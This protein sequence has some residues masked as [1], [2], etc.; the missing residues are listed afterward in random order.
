MKPNFENE[1]PE[2]SKPK[3]QKKNVFIN[4]ISWSCINENLGIERITLK[5]KYTRID[6]VYIASH[7]YKN[8][9][10]ISISEQFMIKES[11]NVK[12]KYKM[13]KAIGIPISPNKFFLKRKGQV[14]HFSILFEPIP[15][16]IE[17][18]DIIENIRF[19]NGFNFFDVELKHQEPTFMRIIYEN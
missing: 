10:W 19:I 13:F 15:T 18:I 5:K 11:F 8:G 12:K 6:F 7:Y 17:N 16:I 1:L 4:P 9:G 3:K 2:N 14:H